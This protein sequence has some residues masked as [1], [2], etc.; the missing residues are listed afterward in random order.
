M[1]KFYP[2]FNGRAEDRGFTAD[3]IKR[4]DHWLYADVT[5]QNCGKVQPVAATSYV[6]GPCVRCGE[7]T[8]NLS[9]RA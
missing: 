3:E 4:G 5:C 8:T 2:K 9:N 1:I 7:L 6:G